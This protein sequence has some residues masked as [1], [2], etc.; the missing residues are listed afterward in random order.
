MARVFG[1]NN[2]RITFFLKVGVPP[3]S[4]VKTGGEIYRVRRLPFRGLRRARVANWPD[5]H[6]RPA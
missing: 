3:A 2:L 6:Q 1:S 5:F 4:N